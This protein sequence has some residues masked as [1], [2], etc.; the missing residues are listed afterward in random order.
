M[1]VVLSGRI[2]A[3]LRLC[4]QASHPTVHPHLSA[5]YLHPADLLPSPSSLLPSTFIFFFFFGLST[6]SPSSLH[7]LPFHLTLHP[8]HPATTTNTTT[9]TSPQ[10]VASAHRPERRLPCC[11]SLSQRTDG[12]SRGSRRSGDGNPPTEPHNPPH[13][14]PPNRET[15]GRRRGSTASRDTCAAGSPLFSLCEA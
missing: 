12:G 15:G 8:L 5:F 11:Q 9:T 14:I 2:R 13:P 4:P 1:H 6:S 7:L 3:E 10:P